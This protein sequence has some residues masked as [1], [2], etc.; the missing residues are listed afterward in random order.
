MR[1]T[2]EQLLIIEHLFHGSTARL[3][4]DAGAATA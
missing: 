4:A 2:E 3:G 1:S